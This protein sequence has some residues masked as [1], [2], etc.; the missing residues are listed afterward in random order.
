M[1]AAAFRTV[2]AYST[3]QE[4]AKQYDQVM[5][6]F[7][8]HFAKASALMAEAKEEILAMSRLRVIHS[9][10]CLIISS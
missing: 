1:V 7:A 10:L 2:F 8:E 3:S 5:G 9:T 6:T 4:M